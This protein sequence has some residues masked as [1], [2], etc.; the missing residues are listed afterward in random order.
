MALGKIVENELFMKDLKNLMDFQ[1]L[2]KLNWKLV[3]FSDD[4]VWTFNLAKNYTR[5]QK[6]NDAFN[7]K[8]H[9]FSV[10]SHINI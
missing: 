5:N 3:I 1:S 6:T 4:L 10:I 9:I 7:Y 8:N 2:W